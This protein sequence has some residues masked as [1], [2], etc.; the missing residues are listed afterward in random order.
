MNV[1]WISFLQAKWPK[2]NIGLP[3]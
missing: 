1:Q 2:Y 3:K